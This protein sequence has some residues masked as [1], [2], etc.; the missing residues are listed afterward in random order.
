MVKNTHAED[1]RATHV[2]LGHP[3]GPAVMFQ[4]WRDLLFVHWRIPAARIQATLPTGLTVD[5]YDGDAYLGVVPF[6]MRNV[7][8]RWL[9]PVP[10]LSNFLELNLRT[11]VRDRAGVPGVWFYSLDANQRLAVAIARHLFHLPYE[12]AT[13][14]TRGSAADGFEF[15]SHRTRPLRGSGRSRIAWVPRG[16]VRGAEPGS[17]E[18]FLAERYR[19]Y[20]DS[21][22]G[23]QRGAVAHA[24]YPLQ[25]A[26]VHYVDEELL[27][28]NG[29]TP[30]GRPPDHVMC[31]SGV[32]VT[33]HPL[34]RVP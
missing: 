11:Y 33:I 15:L 32:D 8:P 27:V 1:G 26:E 7:R 16:A 14:T 25:D 18:F 6:T 4:Q 13:M 28:M 21:P 23:L 3:V 31:S 17:L 5:T 20:A 22:R 29:F 34:L 24:P 2:G 19:L 9:P 12:H 10:G 30:T